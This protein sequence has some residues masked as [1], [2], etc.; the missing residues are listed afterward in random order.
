MEGADKQLTLC[1]HITIDCFGCCPSVHFSI[2]ISLS[3]FSRIPTITTTQ[4]V[5]RLQ[6]H[7]YRLAFLSSIVKKERERERERGSKKDNVG[8]SQ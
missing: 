7:T 4:E 5:K 2:S 8:V 1:V 3:L 6:Q